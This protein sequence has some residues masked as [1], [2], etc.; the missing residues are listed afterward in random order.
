[1]G[2][3]PMAALS[4]GLIG[5]AAPARAEEQ[6][7]PT[8]KSMI[9]GW[10]FSPDYSYTAESEVRLPLLR[11]RCTGRRRRLRAGARVARC[12]EANLAV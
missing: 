5:A 3:W 11:L 8:I 1:M 9:G 2:L 12:P 6:T 4:L 10:M 7:Q